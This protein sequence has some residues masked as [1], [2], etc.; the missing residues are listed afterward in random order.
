MKVYIRWADGAWALLVLLAAVLTACGLA[1]SFS[2]IVRSPTE[3]AGHGLV[4]IGSV[5]FAA[6][7]V[8]ASLRGR[9]P[10]V[11]VL[12][13]LPAVVVGGLSVELPDGLYAHLAG[14]FL[15]PTALCAMLADLLFP[16]TPY[17]LASSLPA[18]GPPA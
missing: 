12:T 2:F 15:I 5:A 7:A 13:V 16:G 1:A 18:D 17:E 9:P 14:L 11:S 8:W 6:C 3:A 10:W 4:F